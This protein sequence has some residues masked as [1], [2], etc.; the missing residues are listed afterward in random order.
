[1]SLR[2]FI[3]L[4]QIA[5]LDLVTGLF[6][7]HVLYLFSGN[8]TPLW[9][10]VLGAIMAVIPDLDILPFVFRQQPPDLT[11][12]NTVIHQPLLFIVLP[13]LIL[14]F[15][16]SSV[17]LLWALPLIF[18]YLH[19]TF[20]T[21]MGLQWL[22]PFSRLKFAFFDLDNRR[23]RRFFVAH[24]ENFSGMT[25]DEALEKKFYRPT[26]TSVLEP[27]LCV[28]LLAVIALTW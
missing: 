12:R 15:F 24:P 1:M 3:G 14:F 27:I 9:A 6:I 8:P 21:S 22:Y 4:F 28:I 26:L 5:A 16:S 23:Q 17:A 18:H 11:H 13:T 7:A 25:L 10:Y 20:G 19:D 2:K